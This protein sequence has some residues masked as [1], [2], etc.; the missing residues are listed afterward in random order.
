MIRYDA[1]PSELPFPL[2]AQEE[3]A[4]IDLRVAREV[5]RLRSDLRRGSSL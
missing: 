5:C 1:G 2:G 3:V 4:V